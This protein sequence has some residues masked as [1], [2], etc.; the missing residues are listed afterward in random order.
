MPSV[1]DATQRR[2]EGDFLTRLRGA[3]ER[4]GHGRGLLS[5]DI[6]LHRVVL[7]ARGAEP[8]RVATG[9]SGWVPPVSSPGANRTG[10]EGTSADN[11]RPSGSQGAPELLDFTRLFLDGWRPRL[12]SFSSASTTTRADQ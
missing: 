1:T 11:S 6:T 4:F 8:D 7:L 9:G 5:R 12:P 3:V 10:V 2:D